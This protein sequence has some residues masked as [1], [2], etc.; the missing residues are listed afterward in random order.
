MTSHGIL[1]AGQL[2]EAGQL[3]A[4]NVPKNDALFTP[5]LEQTQTAAF[6]AIVGDAKYTPGGKL[7]STIFDGVE[8]GY[9][10]IKTGNSRAQ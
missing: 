10:E 1:R 5:S 8:G 9:L 6:K 4:L 3:A 2:H 7:K